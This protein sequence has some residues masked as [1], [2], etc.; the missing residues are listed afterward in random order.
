M[1]GD[2]VA[3]HASGV[4]L[5]LPELAAFTAPWRA[6]SY[7]PDH[8]TMPIERRF[9][10]H[11]TLLTPFAEADDRQALDRLHRVADHH[12][13]FDLTFS[14]AEQFGPGG[15]VWLVPEPH[16]LVLT[17]MCQVIEAFPEYPPY[18]G[19]H[20]DPVPHLTVTTV[21]EADTL[22]QVDAALRQRGP[23]C[24]HVS[25]LGVWQRDCDDAWQLIAPV[26]LGAG[27]ARR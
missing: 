23:L 14:R 24:A 4:I 21:G 13:P 10:P 1:S 27:V 16:D 25:E 12:R 19:L 11:V 15:A 6:T 2:F 17:L 18:E 20:P 7:A 3:S 5:A 26:P 9:P 8:P 22:A